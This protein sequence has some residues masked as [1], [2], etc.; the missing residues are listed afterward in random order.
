MKY[1]IEEIK[2]HAREYI[3]DSLEYD[4]DYLDKDITD[5]HNDIFNTD[6][7]IIGYYNAEKWLGSNAFECIGCIKGYEQDNFGEIYTDLSSSESVVN[8]YVYIIGEEILQDIINEFE[9]ERI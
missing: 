8:M 4:K 2:N 7:Y 5:I 3:K 6:Y 1:K 9:L